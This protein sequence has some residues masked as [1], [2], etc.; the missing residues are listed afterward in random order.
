M[1]NDIKVSVFCLAYNHERYIRS[2]LD[3]FVNQKTNFK[4]EVIVHDDASTDGTAA[5]IAEYAEKHPG[6]IKPIYQTEN[7]YS[8]HINIVKNFIVPHLKGEF[9]AMCEG[10]DYWVDENKLQRQYDIMRANPEVALCTHRTQCV[11][12]DGT[13]NL[14]LLPRKGFA[15]EAD[16]IFD[17]DAFSDLLLIKKSYAFHT[18]SYFMKKEVLV[19]DLRSSIVKK[20]N[21]DTAC[22]FS[23]LY[24][25]KVYYINEV[26]SHRRMMTVGCY[27]ERKKTLP[28]EKKIEHDLKIVDGY[29]LFDEW[30]KGKYHKKV[31]Y[32]AYTDMILLQINKYPKR[33]EVRNY[34]RMFRQA[35]PFDWR[36]SLKLDMAYIAFL[37]CPGLFRLAFHKHVEKAQEKIG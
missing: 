20:M 13:E 12:A 15:G 7:Q 2:A 14:R 9:V 18:S 4:Y 17:Q 36:I 21:G 30:S 29:L 35:R 37:V 25:G 26:M 22:M 1:E 11:S 27:N 28:I 3:G 33:P 34:F 16:K 5:I 31:L 23:A 6:I 32:A 19:S 10:D 8:R 24:F